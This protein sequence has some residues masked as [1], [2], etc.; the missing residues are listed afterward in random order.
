M[1]M[2]VDMSV[3]P[4]AFRKLRA[5]LYGFDRELLGK[6]NSRIKRAVAPAKQDA[7]AAA[8]NLAL[9]GANT[10]SGGRTDSPLARK[11]TRG[12]KTISV[13]VGGRTSRRT[14]TDSVVRLVAENGAMAIAEFAQNSTTKSGAALVAMLDRK[15]GST[16]RFLWD[17]VD[18]HESEILADNRDEVRKTEQEWTDRLASG[19]ATGVLY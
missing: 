12:K 16:G 18:Q 3:D 17:A 2:E 13:K 1:D 14:E 6:L 7:E 8:A 5:E 9:L 10:P 11:Y 19:S 4:A 15:F